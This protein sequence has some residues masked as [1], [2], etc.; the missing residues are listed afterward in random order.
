MCCM[1]IFSAI[2]L[3]NQSSLVFF[4]QRYIAFSQRIAMSFIIILEGDFTLLLWQADITK[5]MVWIEAFLKVT[6]QLD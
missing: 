3:S 1:L 2:F 4:L 5:Y 6:L